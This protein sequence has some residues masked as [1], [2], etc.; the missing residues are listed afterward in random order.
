MAF[1]NSTNTDTIKEVSILED[2]IN[3]IIENKDKSIDKL[4]ENQDYETSIMI[5]SLISNDMDIN[6]RLDIIK[7]CKD[8]KVRELLY[9]RYIDELAKELFYEKAK[10]EKG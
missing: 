2:K 1:W 4:V 9:L 8:S 6:E 3:R 5:N 7:A 10:K